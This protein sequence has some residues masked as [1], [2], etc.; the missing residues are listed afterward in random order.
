MTPDAGLLLVPESHERLGSATFIAEHLSDC[1]HGL[2]TQFR[3]ADL[4]RQSVYSRLA[5]Y[6]D[7]NDAACLAADLTFRLIASPKAPDRGAALTST[8]HW[9]ETELR[10]REENL[11]G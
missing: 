4:L 6:E 2:N 7:L 1:R 9:L 8:L 11:L 10:S 5:A 3:L